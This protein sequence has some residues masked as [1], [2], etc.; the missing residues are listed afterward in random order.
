MRENKSN[1]ANK[2]KKLRRRSQIPFLRPTHKWNGI[3]SQTSPPKKQNLQ[4]RFR[5]TKTRITVNVPA[6]I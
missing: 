2:N 6:E 4:T 1:F 5:G 3:I